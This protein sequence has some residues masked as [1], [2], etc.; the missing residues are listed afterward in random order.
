[1]DFTVHTLSVCLSQ[2]TNN[3]L[4]GGE[5]RYLSESPPGIDSTCHTGD[6]I[7]TVKA[8]DLLEVSEL[9]TG[10]CSPPPSPNTAHVNIGFSCLALVTWCDTRKIRFKMCDTLC[11]QF[12]LKVFWCVYVDGR[13]KWS[14]S[15]WRRRLSGPEW[16][17]LHQSTA[18]VIAAAALGN[19]WS[20]FP[21]HW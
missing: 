4:T 15:A 13:T 18:F 21:E 12:F 14:L 8:L 10:S 9:L 1:M 2:V 6:W 11:D 16:D 20:Y 5:G 7:Q 19:S 17:F 3:P